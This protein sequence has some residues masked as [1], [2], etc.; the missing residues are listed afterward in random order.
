MSAQSDLLAENPR[1][2]VGSLPRIDPT[3]IPEE[4][5]PGNLVQAD[6]INGTTIEISQLLIAAL[7]PTSACW[8]CRSVG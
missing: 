7:V 6:D 3:L 2:P 4:E 5:R 8:G 1:K